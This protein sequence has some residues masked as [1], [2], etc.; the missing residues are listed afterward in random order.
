M[1]KGRSTEYVGVDGR[2][3]WKSQNGNSLLIVSTVSMKMKSESSTESRDR[4]RGECRRC[5]N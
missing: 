5:E 3:R 4:G 1:V 2:K